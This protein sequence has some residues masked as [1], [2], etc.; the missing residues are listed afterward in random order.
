MPLP[1]NPPGAAEAL[2]QTEGAR[3]QSNAASNLLQPAQAAPDANDPV[4]TLIVA[5]HGIGDQKRFATIQSVAH[6]LGRYLDVPG[7]V[8]LGQFHSAPATVEAFSLP[9]HPE[10]GLAEVFWA[11]IPKSAQ[12]NEDT[13]EETKAW[14]STVVER[15]RK[16]DREKT[17]NKDSVDYQKTRAVMTEMIE[18]IA[19]LENLMKIAEKAGLGKFE[20]GDVLDAYLGDVQ[21]VAEFRDYGGRIFEQVGK[22]MDDLVRRHPN[23]DKIYFVAH[24]EGTVVS[25][26]A[27]LS[28][29]AHPVNP[30]RDWVDKVCGYMTI[31]SPIDKHVVMWP[32][33]WDAFKK[34]G[35]NVP[36][37]APT[38][39]TAPIVWWNY[40]D[41]GDPVGF[42]LDTT[43]QWLIDN[44]WMGPNAPG[45]NI[46]TFP[47]EHEVGFTR[48]PLPG[49]AHN[50]YWEDAGVFDH[51]FKNVLQLKR[52]KEG[53][54]IEEEVPTPKT[55]W[56]CWPVSWCLPYV[57]CLLLLMGGTYVVYHALEPFTAKLPGWWDMVKNVSGLACF[58][59]GITVLS[60]IPRLVKIG[61]WHAVA[62]G[63][64][65]F[66][67]WAYSSWVSPRVHEDL[68][69]G[70]A[71][72]P[73]AD[74]QCKLIGVGLTIALLSAIG[75][76]L[77][78]SWGMKPLM[79]L[80]GIATLAALIGILNASQS[81]DNP[82]WPLVL[83][84]LGFL[85][86]W[87]LAALIFDLVF[88]WH[89]YIRS[90]AAGDFLHQT[91][92]R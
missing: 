25:F 57:L 64:F 62:L 56:L 50:D 87:W 49:K 27:L 34:P 30:G 69:K 4:K 83:A 40:Y 78:P 10:I 2:K 12:K 20:L 72:W 38:H 61:K 90:N 53:R 68:A 88:V 35:A 51:F 11:D 76:K 19:T 24:S 92:R 67:S 17:G 82:L 46:F 85:Y 91:Y 39:R 81:P 44:Q 63:V 48:Y 58:I 13:L 5:V 54:E 70:F 22:I 28:A 36:G 21:I 26:H 8:S 73:G 89:R 3:D 1:L 43:R 41:Y 14:A 66:G 71:H 60:R 6:R 29:L 18:T 86:L 9:G 79:A 55:N 45:K 59:A 47:P 84:G 16:R 33:L 15:L 80:A 31:G 52:I 74:D 32:R 77:R 23:A 65:A 7:L 42:Q 75:S 37:I